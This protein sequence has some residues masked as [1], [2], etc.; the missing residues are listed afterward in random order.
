MTS[1]ISVPTSIGDIFDRLSILDIKNQMIK[2]AIK[3]KFINIEKTY[4]EITLSQQL[5]N[6]VMKYYYNIITI[7]NRSI[8]DLMDN[9]R[10]LDFDHP[11][12]AR[13]CRECIIENDRRFKVK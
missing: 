10:T 1:L 13:I 3:L 2:E 11:D 9:L 8:W 7:I 5:Q 6:S 4:L 12:Y